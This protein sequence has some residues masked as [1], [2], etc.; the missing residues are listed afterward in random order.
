MSRSHQRHAQKLHD[1]QKQ[2]HGHK[3]ANR[4]VPAV[5]KLKLFFTPAVDFAEIV[6]SSPSSRKEG[7]SR[8]EE[9]AY[10]EEEER[11]YEQ[12]EDKEVPEYKDEGEMQ[13]L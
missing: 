6:Q 4:H 2:P 8:S 10:E 12:G 1:I 13:C 9:A 3:R 7:S 11:C 5:P